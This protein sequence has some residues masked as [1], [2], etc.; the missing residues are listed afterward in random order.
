M[1]KILLV[2]DDRNYVSLM[3]IMLEEGGHTVGVAFDGIEGG[4]AFTK[5][6]YDV[7]VTDILMPNKDGIKFIQSLRKTHPKLP[8]LAVSGGHTYGHMDY[9]AVAQLAGATEVLAKP[10]TKQAL[11]SSIRACLRAAS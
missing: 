9:L 1:S 2:D 11:L 5:D 4:K 8:I 6:E 10:F 3:K 7:V